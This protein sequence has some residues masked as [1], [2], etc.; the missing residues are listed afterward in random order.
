MLKKKWIPLIITILFAATIHGSALLMLPIVFIVQGKAW[1]KKTIGFIAVCIVVLAFTDQFTN[2][3]DTLL[4]DTQYTNVVSDWQGLNDDGTNIIRVLV[5]SIPMILA[6]IGRKWL[7]IED[8]S[9]MNLC[10]NMSIVTSGLYLVSA[11][12]SGVFLGRLPIF[13]SL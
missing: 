8:D 9:V 11:V 12:T 4:S 6:F 3:L 5:Y 7:E 10:T 1:N 2:I 13:T